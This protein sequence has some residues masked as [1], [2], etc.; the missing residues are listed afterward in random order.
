[1]ENVTVNAIRRRIRTWGEG[2]DTDDLTR[3]SAR[4]LDYRCRDYRARRLLFCQIDA[5]ETIVYITE[6]AKKNSHAWIDTDNATGSARTIPELATAARLS[7]MCCYYE[8]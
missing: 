6:V 4:L 1:M 5:L 2:R 8:V 3:P 7:V